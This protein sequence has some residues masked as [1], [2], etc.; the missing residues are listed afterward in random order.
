VSRIAGRHVVLGVSGGIA[1]YKAC[2]VARRLTERGAD[3][4]TVLTAAAA[5]F[6]GP[7]TF[8]ALTGHPV[9][10]SLWQPGRALDHVRLGRETHLIVVAPATAHLIARMAQGMADDF[11]TALLLA[12]S[13]P[14]LLCPAMNDR[15][16]T[17]PETQANLALLR[18][19]GVQVLGPA[20]GPLARGEGEGPGRMVEPEAIVAYAERRLRSAAPWDG[21]RVL[22]TAGPTREALDPVRV[23]TNRSSGRMGH[24]LASAAWLRGAE[25]ILVSGPTALDAPWGVETVRV[26]TTSQMAEAVAGALPLCDV[27]LMAAAPADH[28]MSAPLERKAPR[29]DGALRV[30]LEPTTDILVATVERRKKGAI[31]VGFALE[32]GDAVAKARAKLKTKHL[33]LVIANDATEPGAGPEVPTNR[34]TVV[35]AEGAEPLPLMTKGEA[36]EAILDR[37]QVLL[38]KGG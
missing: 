5:E 15:M 18:S 25:V 29:A 36:A 20:T 37:V 17:H 23:V 33:D 28:R 24:A 6:V 10:T 27:V 19:R 35:S 38:S 32:T 8:E 34:V 16:Y 13:A 7:V 3:V 2:V 14:L 11:L 22:V 9:I 31:V 4:E 26:E 1:C 12:R 30:E 21:R